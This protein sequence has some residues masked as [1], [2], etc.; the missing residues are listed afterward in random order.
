MNRQSRYQQ[1]EKLVTILILL[2]FLVFVVFLIASGNAIIWLKVI[3]CIITILLCGL[4]LTVLYMTKLLIKSRSLWMT[5]AS[6]GI[7]ICLIF[8][9]LLNYPS[10]V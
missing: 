2:S 7:L 9:L 5:C 10:P 3:S 1:I 4:S 8:S 6:A